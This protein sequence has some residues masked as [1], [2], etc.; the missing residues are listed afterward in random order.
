MDGMIHVSEF[1]DGF[2]VATDVK[3]WRPWYGCV[4]RQD[5][6]LSAR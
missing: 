2:V 1:K 6:S 5:W 4:E 3:A